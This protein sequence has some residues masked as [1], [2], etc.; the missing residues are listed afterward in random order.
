MIEKKYD[1]ARGNRIYWLDNLRTFM[2]FLVVLIH[3][4]IVYESSSAGA[5]FWIVDDPSTSSVIE[6]INR[7]MDIFV[8]SSI[9][10]VSGY[11]APLSLKNKNSW[12][13]IKSK[14]RRLMIPWILAVITL[15]PLY[16]IIFLYSRNISQEG[17]TTYFHWNNG[18]FSQ[19]WLW[20]L[21]VLF[22]FDILY[23]FFFKIRIDLS[24]INLKRFVWS[25]FLIG[26]IY[27]V[28][29][30]IF[31]GQGWTKTILIDFQNERLGVYFMVFLIGSFCYKSGAFA[32]EP[33]SKKLYI[34][35]LCTVWM[36]VIL[37]NFFFKYPFTVQN[38]YIFSESIDI[39]ILHLSFMLSLLGL[40]YLF[41]NTFRF[42][43]NKSGKI[44]KE[45]NKNSYGV[46]I[47]HVIVL[48]G[49]A[50]IMLNT[51]IPSL[52]KYLILTVS[53]FAVCNLI[54]YFYREVIKSRILTWYSH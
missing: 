21:P 20:F 7:I 29:M 42:Y 3:A 34:I 44:I 54:V 45:L 28:C 48:G 12:T 18:I 46:Y 27:L 25:G 31:N 52:L 13:F 24:K 40:L 38:K 11:F 35:T 14:F 47:I 2:I 1:A 23:L 15:M 37:Y 39:L 22:L 33:T 17:W 8:M 32:S 53:T 16:K 30:D 49:I 4:G 51:I 9:F 26:F 10:F 50:L 41:I 6:I 43:L 36:P 5:F 19:N